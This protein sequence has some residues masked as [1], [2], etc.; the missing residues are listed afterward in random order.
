MV[1]N[2]RCIGKGVTNSNGVAQMTHSSSDNGVTFT[3]LVNN[4]YEG[5]GSGKVYIVA[6][7]NNLIVDGS[8]Q[9]E[10]Y[11]ILDTRFY[12]KGLD[13]SGNHNDNW[14]NSNIT[15]TRG[16]EST[17]ITNT[18]SANN[19]YW[20][21]GSTSNMWNQSPIM[22]LEVDI[23]SADIGLAIEMGQ[24]NTTRFNKVFSNTLAI[25]GETHVKITYDGS[26]YELYFD[27]VL[28]GS[29][30]KSLVEGESSRVGFSGKGTL[31]YKNF[32]IY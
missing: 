25:T 5:S 13:G 12:D 24:N 26:I 32:V 30:E 8:V 21:A 4:G 3:Q 17:T 19:G 9:S 23:I 7:T 27:D 10:P 22:T 6:S 28:K 11:S 31:V 2:Y 18:N 20:W 14:F 29:L 15:V 16:S 1:V